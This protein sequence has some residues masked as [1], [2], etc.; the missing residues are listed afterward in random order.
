MTLSSVH[1]C[2]VLWPLLTTA[3]QEHPTRA[4]VLE[5]LWPSCLAFTLW[6][7]W[8]SLKSLHLP[9]FPASNTSTLRTK[10]SM[11]PNISHP[12]IL[13]RGENWCYSLHL[14][15]VIML[16]LIDVH[17]WGPWSRKLLTTGKKFVWHF[18]NFIKN[19]ENIT[20]TSQPVL[21][22]LLKHFFA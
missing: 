8:N 5:M 19:K 3:D 4:A 6:P 15:V 11:L 22:T 14:S 10:C 12:P 9:I 16:R 21:N 18:C 13:W 2:S 17:S 7:L 20:W 1:H